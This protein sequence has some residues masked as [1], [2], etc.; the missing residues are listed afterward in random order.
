MDYI[1]HDHRFALNIVESNPELKSLWEE[2]LDVIA[3]ISDEE[4]ISEYSS[5]KSRMSISEAINKLIDRK[6]VQKGW[7]PQSAIFQGEEY[8]DKKWKLD[9]S[10]KINQP[11]KGI[12]GMAVEVAFN[13]GEAI[14]WN[15]MKP[16]LAAEINQVETQ[17]NI[18]SGVGVYICATADLKEH[19]GFDGAVGE[20]EKV[21]RYLNPMFQKLTAPL[22]ILG[23][24]APKSFRI[25]KTK[26]PITKKTAGQVVRL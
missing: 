6:L 24:E 13:H 22:I 10:K 4:L 1:T 20:Y 5:G 25:E 7:T 15:L 11:Q 9:F 26:N 2:I 16:V 23:L 3:S 12:T 17:T 8:S 18:G 14:A 21:L 19:G